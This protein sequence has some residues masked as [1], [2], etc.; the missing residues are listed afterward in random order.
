MNVSHDPK[1]SPD[2]WRRLHDRLLWLQDRRSS[3]SGDSAVENGL[4]SN[5]HPVTEP[6]ELTML[7][8]QI[9]DLQCLLARGAPTRPEGSQCGTV[10][11][12]SRVT[13]Q[14]DDGEQEVYVI[15]GPTEV[16][17][18]AGRISYSSPLGQSLIG[19]SSGDRVEVDTPLG[20]RWLQ[21]LKVE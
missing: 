8:R 2:R 21:V 11:A 13:L 16:D 17:P 6:D 12:G 3:V 20:R 7:D 15:V 10:G 4:E 1:L 19:R 9:S 18:R 14:W 5:P